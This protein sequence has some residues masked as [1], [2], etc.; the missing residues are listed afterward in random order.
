MDELGRLRELLTRHAGEG[1]TPTSLLGVS[2]L[3]SR[4]TTERVG[5]ITEP[6][7]AVI[8]QGAKE[9]ALNGRIFAYG[10]GQFVLTSLELPVVGHIVQARADEPF[11]S[12]VLRLRPAKIA[13]L[14]LET[15]P[16]PAVRR[17][18]AHATASGIAVSQASP[19]LLDAV[20]RLLALLD[21]PG[22]AVALADG[23]E[24]EILWRLVT[25]PQGATVRQ[26]G[27]ADSGLAHLGRAI[28]HIRFNYNKAL[29]VE[30]LAGLATMSVSSFHRH[31]RGVT[32]MTPIQFQKQVRLQEAR[33]RLLAEPADVAGVGFAVGYDSPS[34]FSRE[35]RRMFGLPPSRDALTMREAALL[36]SS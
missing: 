33:V 9:T 10:P 34:Q 24:R 27:L 1:L 21:S 16:T 23:I 4:T 35:Y 7:L 31:F 14:L 36:P 18:E 8:A 30:E 22:D 26:I 12:F 5:D 17:G 32:S 13:A 19:A 20:G 6:T 25:G 29:R 15:A 2:V 3:C 11:L 28:R